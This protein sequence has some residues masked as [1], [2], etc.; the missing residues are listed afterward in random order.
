MLRNVL[1]IVVIIFT[2]LFSSCVT[3]YDESI[4][5]E[6]SLVI[7]ITTGYFIREYNEI[8]VDWRRG[9]LVL[10]AGETELFFGNIM[11]DYGN[12]TYVFRQVTLYFTFE[13][14][15][16]VFLFNP[17]GGEDER[18]MG[19]NV[20]RQSPNTSIRRENFFVFLPLLKV[21][22]IPLTEPI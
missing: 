17:Y 11:A 5:R 10:P 4:P 18:T 14:G 21:K 1:L 7:T 19:F 20:Y 16:Y 15:E 22:S 3:V 8:P 13:P 12:R 2:V 9:V 6:E